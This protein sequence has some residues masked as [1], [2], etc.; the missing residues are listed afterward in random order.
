MLS[1][2]LTLLQV[3]SL[4]QNNCRHSC[5]G[6]YCLQELYLLTGDAWGPLPFSICAA[7][8]CQ[9]CNDPPCLEYSNLVSYNP[10]CGQK[11]CFWL[12]TWHY[13]GNLPAVWSN[14]SSL[15]TLA[16]GDNH[17]SGES[18]ELAC[19]S[20]EAALLYTPHIVQQRI[21]RSHQML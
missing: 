10:P 3:A 12:G 18:C 7:V 14:L 6:V 11:L 17:L 15:S 21:S 1:R 13:A 9:V 19:F 16:L 8:T 20:H 4:I 2:Y 5:L